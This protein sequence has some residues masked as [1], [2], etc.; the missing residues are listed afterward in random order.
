MDN[1]GH[2]QSG[3]HDHRREHGWHESRRLW[4][5]QFS[6]QQPDRQ[7]RRQLR[8]GHLRPDWHHRPAAQPVAGTT[9]Q[10]RRPD[11]D[12]GPAYRQPAIDAGN[13][14]LVPPGVTTDQ[15]GLP[16][17]SPHPTS[18]PS[19]AIRWWSTPRSMVILPP[20]DLSLRQAVNLA[21][22]LAGPERSR[23]TRL[24]SPPPRPSP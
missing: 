10:L 2:D 15:R 7:D 13:V 18:A 6:G 5:L 23:S 19:R 21:N 17:D 9:G 14:A 16:L 11:P 3:Q 20:G 4:Q 24:S 1:S 12:D 22:L 8:L